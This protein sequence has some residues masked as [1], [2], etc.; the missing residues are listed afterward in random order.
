MGQKYFQDIYLFISLSAS[1]EPL[2]PRAVTPTAAMQIRKCHIISDK[3]IQL[4]SNTKIRQFDEAHRHARDAICQVYLDQMEYVS[5][6]ISLCSLEM[7]M[8]RCIFFCQNF[9][10][11]SWS[12][13]EVNERSFWCKETRKSCWGSF[14]WKQN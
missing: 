9:N 10:C 12:E 3:T 5:I 2:V 8:I 7:E 6:H 1:P 4:P 11:Q 14:C 13:S